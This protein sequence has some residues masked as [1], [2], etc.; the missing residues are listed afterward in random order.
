MNKELLDVIKTILALTI[1]YI[2]ELIQSKVV[3]MLKRKA[4]E[5]VDAKIDKLINDLVQNASKIALEENEIKK[6]AY[7]QGTKL[8]IET[9][10]ALATKLNKAAEE[11]EKVI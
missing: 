2:R 5:K 8:G 9:L 1:P 11:I 4:Y 7:I 3:P 6:S 10:K